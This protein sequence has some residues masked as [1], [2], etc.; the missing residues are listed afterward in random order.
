MPPLDDDDDDDDAIPLVPPELDDD[1][2]VELP[3]G[4][5]LD[6]LDDPLGAGWVPAVVDV[7]VPDDDEHAT[8][9]PAIETIQS[10]RF[11]TSPRRGL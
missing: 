9:I 4:M 11:M 5:P 2:D 10:V 1:E 7:G 8:T 6:P 3:L